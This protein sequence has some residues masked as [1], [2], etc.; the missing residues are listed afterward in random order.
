MQDK[1][2]QIEVALNFL[3]TLFGK[4]IYFKNKDIV[5]KLSSLRRSIYY[6][7]DFEYYLFLEQLQSIEVQLK[8]YD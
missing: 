7:D 2:I 6:K 3:N 5:D 4:A 1:V 8:K